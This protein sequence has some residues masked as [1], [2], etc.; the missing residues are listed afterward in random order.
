MSKYTS[1]YSE[2]VARLVEVQ[3]LQKK[4]AALQRRTDALRRG[5]EINALC[6]AS[7]VLLSSHI[8]AYIKELGE[9]VVDCM[10]RRNVCRS[11]VSN[12]FFYHISKEKIEAIK[13]TSDHARISDFI[14]DFLDKDSMLWGKADP[15]PR[16]IDIGIFN[17][18]F[19][20]PKFEKVKAYLGRFGYENYRKDF[21][22]DLG[23]QG[24][25]T[26]NSLDAIVN[27]R[28]AIAHG[29]PEATKTPEELKTLLDMSK[30]FCRTT[31]RVF[32]RWCYNN[33]CS[34]R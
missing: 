20:N 14:F 31:D 29:D 24:N 6:R 11:K 21:L 8:E 1:V 12:N 13:S 28:N 25:L 30:I 33:L 22:R 2:F 4:A 19:A 3:L 5:E 26:I 32:S 10:Y 23:N 7:V 9:H 17:K 34:I 15:F 16:S 18:G 27:A